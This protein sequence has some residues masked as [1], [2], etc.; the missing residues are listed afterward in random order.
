MLNL[1]QWSFPILNQIP[2]TSGADYIIEESSDIYKA[3][4]NEEGLEYIPYV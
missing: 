2:L 4:V 1:R 3:G